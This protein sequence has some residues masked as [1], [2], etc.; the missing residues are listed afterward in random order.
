MRSIA[1]AC[2]S[3]QVAASLRRPRRELNAGSFSGKDGQPGQHLVAPALI[4]LWT[5][6]S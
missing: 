5:F 2:S 3:R 6:L 1:I 4:L